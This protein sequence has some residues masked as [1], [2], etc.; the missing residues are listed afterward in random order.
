MKALH[1]FLQILPKN[2]LKSI[3]FRR[4]AQSSNYKHTYFFGFTRTGNLIY[5]PI[6]FGSNFEYFGVRKMGKWNR[7]FSD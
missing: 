7:L 3:L 2:G 5:N 1:N 6:I 4:D